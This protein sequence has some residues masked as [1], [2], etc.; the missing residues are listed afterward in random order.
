MSNDHNEVNN[1]EQLMYKYLK[2]KDQM[3]NNYDYQ[4]PLKEISPIEPLIFQNDTL[5]RNNQYDMNMQNF[6]PRFEKDIDIPN[7]LSN[8]SDRIGINDNNK[9]IT[10][11]KPNNKNSSNI[12]SFI[13][14]SIEREKALKEEK[15]KKQLEYQKMLDEQI[16]EKRLRQ[17][18]EKEKRLKEELLFE[19]KLKL[20]KE[21]FERENN[22]NKNI[23]KFQNNNL[24]YR[25]EPIQI[26]VKMPQFSQNLMV[27]NEMEENIQSE[28]MNNAMKRANSQKYLEIMNNNNMFPQN[29]NPKY[30]PNPPYREEGEEESPENLILQNQNINQNIPPQQISI[31]HLVS[32]SSQIPGQ[33]LNPLNQNHPQ[34]KT[35]NNY[36]PGSRQNQNLS[37]NIIPNLNNMNYPQS[38]PSSQDL[39][40]YMTQ[41]QYYESRQKLHRMPSTDLGSNTNISITPSNFPTSYQI[42][43]N[44]NLINSSP[45]P[46][47]FNSNSQ[48]VNELLNMNINNQNYFGKIME[49]FF[50]EQE[51]ILESYKETIEKLK[52]ERDEAIYKNKA[53]EQKILALQKLQNDQENLEKNLGYFP[54]KNNYQ[55]NMEKTLDSI[56]QKNEDFNYNNDNENK[57]ININENDNKKI[58][59]SL[60]NI[61]NNSNIS[62][63]KLVSLITSTKFVKVNSGDGKKLLETWKKEEEDDNK[64][65]NNYNYD[66]KENKEYLNNNNLNVNVNK[67]DQGNMNDN[68]ININNRFKLNGMDTNAF[69]EKI[70]MI[71]NKILEPP[72]EPK[73]YLEDSIISKTQKNDEKSFAN[74]IN[75]RNVKE[76]INNID[77]N[78]IN[79]NDNNKDNIIRSK[80]NDIVNNYISND[81]TEKENKFNNFNYKDNIANESDLNMQKYIAEMEGKDIMLNNVHNAVMQNLDNNISISTQ[82][83]EKLE[84]KKRQQ[85]INN[86]NINNNNAI[87]I[88]VISEREYQG[89]YRDSEDEEKKNKYNNY[90]IKQVNCSSSKQIK[91]SDSKNNEMKKK[92]KDSILINPPLKNIDNNVTISKSKNNYSLFVSK[93]IKNEE[94]N[95]FENIVSINDEE[96]TQNNNINNKNININIAE[97]EENNDLP[98]LDSPKN[99]YKT[100]QTFGVQN[101][102]NNTITNKNENNSVSKSK[103]KKDEEIIN[104]LNFFEDDDNILASKI[105]LDKKEPNNNNINNINIDN[106]SFLKN[107]SNLIYNNKNNES[108][109]SVRP[110]SDLT[111]DKITSLNNLYDEFK[112]KK[113][114]INETNNSVSNNNINNIGNNSLMNE[115]LNTFTQ[116]LNIKWKDLTKKDINNIK[117]NREQL[118]NDDNN[119]SYLDDEDNF[120]DEKIFDKVNQ[121][122]RVALNELKQSQLSVF[123]KDK[124]F[125]KYG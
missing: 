16:K 36:Y 30:P 13:N 40:P 2:D 65:N 15:K 38:Q 8:R 77:T 80:N 117:M 64:N 59:T 115:S 104:R 111:G 112:K 35:Q 46:I 9:F 99:D 43:F 3:L 32:T 62:D 63:S 122:T 50:H 4:T 21:K 119:Y 97:G 53:N 82:I 120:K 90:S 87:K 85:E 51:K 26:K 37:Q 110:P 23:N 68:N 74:E 6:N 95:P 98:N 33:I 7:N 118:Y 28:M 123:S 86:D 105:K 45:N 20:E 49:I 5:P 78:N 103:A 116:N 107:N 114:H 41:R 70:S 108:K 101:N 60:N 58:E 57:M 125:K 17:Q 55:Q 71:N 83:K 11:S 106:D 61:N 66:Y 72:D 91:I 102:N 12:N 10:P 88:S 121:F 52:N 89:I 56:M 54:F 22:Q 96:E 48:N 84:E 27:D 100:V 39:N 109:H 14:S 124:T 24:F 67:K 18:K 47:N 94:K 34:Y 44:N 92:E 29:Q 73:N 1:F 69:M 25:E 75:N 79:I 19:E 76:E 113:E 42:P 81:I 31:E 93:H